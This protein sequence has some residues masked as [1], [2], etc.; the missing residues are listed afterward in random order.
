MWCVTCHTPFDWESGR[1]VTTGVIHNPHYFEFYRASGQQVPR[2][3]QEECG[4]E[5]TMNQVLRAVSKKQDL[6]EISLAHNGIWHIDMVEIPRCSVF[7]ISDP[8]LP[9]LTC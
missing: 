7:G 6:K 2:P 8:K 3:R 4:L 9:A 5:P 1:E